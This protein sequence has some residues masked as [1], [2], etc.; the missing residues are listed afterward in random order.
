MVTS[1]ERLSA[2]SLINQIISIDS[3]NGQHIP[4]SFNYVTRHTNNPKL[5]PTIFF[6][7]KAINVISSIKLIDIDV[8][9]F[10]E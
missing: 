8:I 10:F 2:Y 7:Q 9:L 5:S 4:C 6:R 1:K 3:F